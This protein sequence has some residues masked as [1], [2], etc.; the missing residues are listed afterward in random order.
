MSKS[1]NSWGDAVNIASRMESSAEIGRV[2]VSEEVRSRLRNDFVFA[3]RGGI[4]VKGKGKGLLRTYYL[5]AKKQ[6]PAPP[7]R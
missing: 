7:D 1:S 6:G 5:T 4:E 2:H 3:E